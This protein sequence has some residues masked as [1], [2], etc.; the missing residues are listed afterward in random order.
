MLRRSFVYSCICW[1]YC[2]WYVARA[3]ITFSENVIVQKV[4]YVRLCCQNCDEIYAL[5]RNLCSVTKFMFCDEIYALWRNSCSIESK[6]MTKIS[7]NVCKNVSMKYNYC[8]VVS[9]YFYVQQYDSVDLLLGEKWRPSK[10]R[11]QGIS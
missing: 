3:F 2:C 1:L 11:L 7:L 8:Q 9:V 4:F 6:I 10:M 5:W